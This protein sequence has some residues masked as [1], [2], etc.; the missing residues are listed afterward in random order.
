[1]SVL[2]PIVGRVAFPWSVS[3]DGS[4]L[5][6]FLDWLQDW[7]SYTASIRKQDAVQKSTELLMDAV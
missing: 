7:A 2:R 1:M 4:P 5:F 3:F 6:P